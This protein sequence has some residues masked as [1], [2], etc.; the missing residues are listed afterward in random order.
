[1]DS[2]K[3]RQED[4]QI[5]KDYFGS[6]AQDYQRAFGGSAQSPLHEIVNRLFRRQTFLARTRIVHDLL[7]QH[8]MGP[9]KH[10]LDLGCGSGEVSIMAAQLGAQ[11]TGIDIVEDMVKLATQQAEAAGV[12]DH[13]QFMVR[14]IF[15]ESLPEVDAAMM[16]GVVEYYADITD[17]LATITG[18]TREMVIIVDT[19]G[20]FW[21]RQLRYL[22]ATLKHFRIYYRDPPE[23]DRLMAGFGFQPE[24]P[25][26]GHSF[27]VLVYTRQS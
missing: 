3:V 22:L 24:T 23:I 5:A 13:T 25:I 6:F 16:I 9:G 26:Y 8:G 17:L 2:D 14:D 11:V 15:K 10:V 1:M 20:P 18:A 4:T 27:V 12:A 21:R 19:A 7:V